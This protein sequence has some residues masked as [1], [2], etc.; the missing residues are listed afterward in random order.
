MAEEKKATVDVNVIVTVKVS[1]KAH[2][3]NDIIKVMLSMSDVPVDA[4]DEL[5]KV[6]AVNNMVEVIEKSTDFIRAVCAEE[7]RTCFIAVDAVKKL[8]ILNTE[9]RRG[10]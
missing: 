2:C 3:D 8:T 7:D 10:E 1:Y 5:I 6:S 4:N 9:I